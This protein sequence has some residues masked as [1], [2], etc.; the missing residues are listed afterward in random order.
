MLWDFDGEILALCIVALIVGDLFRL[1]TQIFSLDDHAFIRFALTSA[2]FM[3]VGILRDLFPSLTIIK[4]LRL[5]SFSA[6]PYMW[7][8]F[9]LTCLRIKQNRLRKIALITS[10]PIIVFATLVITNIQHGDVFLYSRTNRFSGGSGL[11]YL[12]VICFFFCILAILSVRIHIKNIQRRK[13]VSLVITPLIFIGTYILYLGIN[14]PRIFNYS[15]LI[16]ILATY[17]IIQNRFS[18]Y[19]PRNGVVNYH[20]FKSSLKRTFAQS[21]S[22]C[23]VLIEV[24]NSQYLINKHGQVA[25]AQLALSLGGCFMEAVVKHLVFCLERNQFVLLLRNVTLV[26]AQQISNCILEK[27][28]STWHFGKFNAVIDLHIGIIEYPTQASTITEALSAMQ[29]LHAEL[30]VGGHGGPLTYSKELMLRNQRKLE[31]HEAVRRSLHDD[32]MVLQYQPIY[33]TMTRKIVSAEV[34]LRLQDPLMGLIMPNEFI[35]IAEESGL[36]IELTYRIIEAACHFWKSLEPLGI[37]LESLSINLS[38]KSFFEPD[39][40]D[41]VV[42]ILAK[43]GVESRFI[44]F[45]L[46]ESISTDSFETVKP[47]MDA[48]VGKGFQFHMDDYGKGYSSMEYLLHLPFSTVKFDRSIILHSEKHFEVLQALVF[49]MHQL[50]RVIVAEG[51]ETEEQFALV[52]QAGINRTQ[53]FLLSRPVYPRVL[54]QLILMN[55]SHTG[56]L[57]ASVNHEKPIP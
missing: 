26:E 11:L 42:S 28:S 27:F 22:G 31:V 8:L 10:M 55:H 33:D 41:R 39:F 45:E 9:T 2:V 20:F 37:N 52:K 12:V 56:M 23:L 53:G 48:L 49:M 18:T 6:P 32:S 38:M 29:F 21:N 46:T 14:E 44:H 35:S 5:I 54:T 19:D 13:A 40:C 57:L 1:R 4:M 47:V 16:I 7:L 34:L 3:T 24:A 17:L 25:G 43:Q 15:I 51:V 50:G 30:Q 36:V